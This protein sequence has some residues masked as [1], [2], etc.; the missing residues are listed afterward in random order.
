MAGAL[1][2]TVSVED[3]RWTET[4]DGVEALGE[5]AARAAW[6][7]SALDGAV[8]EAGLVLMDDAGVR[9]LNRDYR[10]QDKATNVLSF[11]ALDG[12]GPAPVAGQPLVLGDIVVAFETTRD[13]ARDQGRPL[14]DHFSH[15]VVHGMLHLLG[16]DHEDD[17]EAEA[18]EAMETAIMAGLGLPDPYAPPPEPR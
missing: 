14:A 6:D 2:L 10:G 12:G 7:R 11:A 1:A 5:R 9:D 3:P 4:L 13:E 17:A 18:M 15:L 16:H 8:A